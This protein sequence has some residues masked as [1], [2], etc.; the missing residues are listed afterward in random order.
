M[1]RPGHDDDDDDDVSEG[2]DDHEEEEEEEEDEMDWARHGGFRARGVVN[3]RG[4]E[5]RRTPYHPKK[6]ARERDSADDP[7]WAEWLLGQGA[8]GNRS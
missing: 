5:T 4:G 7:G 6:R 3:G 8:E 1:R 2:D